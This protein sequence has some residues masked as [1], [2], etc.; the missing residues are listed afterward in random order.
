MDIREASVDDTAQVAAVC[1]ASSRDRWTE[2]MLAPADDRVVFV[3]VREGEVIGV[4]KTH[5][6][7]EP[8]GEA[9]AGHYLGGI[10]VAPDFRRRGVGG[11]LTRSRLDWI[12]ARAPQAYYFT[13]EENVASVRMH[14]TLGFQLIGGFPEIRGRTA[15]NPGS[16]LLL[17][18]AGRATVES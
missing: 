16:V 5:F 11:G 17:F 2:E 15:D 6:H 9:P 7:G 4:A 13:D 10:V 12:W 14:A 18:V 1:D 3:A 8:D